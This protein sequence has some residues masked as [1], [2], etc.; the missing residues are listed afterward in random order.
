MDIV[1]GQIYFNKTKTYLTPCMQAYGDEF[2][3]RIESV[4]KL[5]IGIGD[6]IVNDLEIRLRNH[7]FILVDSKLSRKNF[8]RNLKWFKLQSYYAFDYPFDDIHT[9]HLHMIVF[10]VPED[11]R[12]TLMIFKEGIYSKMYVEEDLKKFF[13]E[14]GKAFKVMTK[15]NAQLDSFMSHLNTL[16]NTGIPNKE[17]DGEL[18][19]PIKEK[20][21]YFNSNL[22]IKTNGKHYPLKEGQDSSKKA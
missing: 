5:A 21:E 2:V 14:K 7:I 22:K 18:D 19:F 16:Y 6:F 20:E 13:N 9:G 4:F 1:L 3:N 10:R 12:D 11:Y 15:D 8:I 17:W